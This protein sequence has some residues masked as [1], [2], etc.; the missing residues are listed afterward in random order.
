MK[1][2]MIEQSA[3]GLVGRICVFAITTMTFML[4]LA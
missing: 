2:V 3:L 4:A 1:P